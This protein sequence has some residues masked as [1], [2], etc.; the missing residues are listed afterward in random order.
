[1][2]PV[3]VHFRYPE[4]G[5]QQLRRDCPVFLSDDLNHDSHASQAFAQ[6]VVA[7]LPTVRHSEKVVLVS[8]GCSAQF[9]SRLPF[10]YQSHTQAPGC[11]DM[12]VEKVFFGARH[13]KNDSDWCGGA[14]KRAVT[15]DIAAG[16][17]TVRTA[18]EMYE[19]CRKTLSVYDKGGC[20][21]KVQ[22]F[23]LVESR[24]SL[25]SWQLVCWAWCLGAEN[26]II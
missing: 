23:F 12:E 6:H 7:Y 20:Q 1:M 11:R 15:R 22:Q 24:R 17:V 25:G 3:V 10:L 26:S 14:V 5:C 4:A 18:G 13:G 9:K 19:H 8:D 16:I 2:H 21:H